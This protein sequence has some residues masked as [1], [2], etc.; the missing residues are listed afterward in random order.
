MKALIR[1]T[2]VENYSLRSLRKILWAV[3]YVVTAVFCVKKLVDIRRITASR[4]V[5]TK[6]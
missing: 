1:L 2:V 5:V 3:S 4:I 6:R